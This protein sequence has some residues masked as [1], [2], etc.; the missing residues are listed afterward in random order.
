MFKFLKK[1]KI[2]KEI[3][4]PNATNFLKNQKKNLLLE[5]LQDK[6]VGNE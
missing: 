4:N 1:A 3:K 2:K 5:D 6:N